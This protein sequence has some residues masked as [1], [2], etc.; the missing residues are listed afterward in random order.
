M[1][2]VFV[3]S[4]VY[5]FSKT[6]GLADVAISLPA[7]LNKKGVNTIIVTPLYSDINREKFKIVSTNKSFK[8]FINFANEHIEIFE[9]TFKNIK[10]YFLHNKNYFNTDK[11]YE[12]ENSGIRFSLLCYGALELCKSLHFQPDIFHL[13]DWQTS[14]VSVLLKTNYSTDNFFQKTQTLLTIHNLAYQG[15]FPPDILNRIG[16]PFQVFHIDALEFYGQVNF[17][18]GGIVFSDFLNTVSPTYAKE[19]LTFEAGRGLDG[20]LLKRKESLYGILNGIDYEIYNPETDTFLFANYSLDSIEKKVLNKVELQKKLKLGTDKDKVIFAFIGRLT[21][22]K[23]IELVLNVMENLKYINAQMVL[24]GEGDGLYKVQLKKMMS[25]Y[26]NKISVS[27]SFNEKLARQI[28]AGADFFL[29]P[30]LFEP[31]GISQL[32]SMRYGT[33][34]IVRAVGGLKDSVDNNTGFIFKNF[35]KDEFFDMMLKSMEIYYTDKGKI[36]EMK[37]NCMSKNFSWEKSAEKYIE[38]Y[39]KMI[40][41][42]RK[43]YG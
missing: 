38:I 27:F 31:C 13:N 35:S 8:V 28:Y 25:K 3:S 7:T 29:M 12:G 5:P 40:K 14:L 6:G 21:E 1:R 42:R 22:Q 41:N 15:F 33:I 2:A 19:I 10:I 20:V 32:I 17:L 39:N 34:P 9:T 36:I 43:L 11:Y 4:E 18:K 23:G 37:K 26:P 30:S 24:L 16:I